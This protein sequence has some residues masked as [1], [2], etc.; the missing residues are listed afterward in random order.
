MAGSLSSDQLRTFHRE[1]IARLKAH[2]DELARAESFSKR[3][4]ANCWI[5]EQIEEVEA[6]LRNVERKEVQR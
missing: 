2:Y 4:S 5:E 3:T 1:I 6:S